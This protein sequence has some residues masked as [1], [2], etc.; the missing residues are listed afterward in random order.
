MSTRKPYRSRTQ[1]R[2]ARKRAV[3]RSMRP[4]SNVGGGQGGLMSPSGNAGSAWG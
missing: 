2:Y 3:Q 4:I 1:Q